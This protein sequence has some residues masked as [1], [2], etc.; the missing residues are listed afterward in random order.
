MR[1]ATLNTWGMRGDWE[2][3]RAAMREGFTVLGADI[4]LLQETI[5]TKDYDQARDVLGDGYELV[6]QRDREPD[7]QGITTASRYPV[8]RTFEVDWPRSPTF[9][10]TC[11]VTELFVPERV[12]VANH[13]PDWQ[14]DHE[15]RRER[16]T[17]AAARALE[18]LDGHVIVGGD[19]D[20]DPDANSVRFWTGRH[21][22]DG[23]SVCYRDAWASRHP[24]EPGH[25]FVPENPY[26]ADWDWP[27]RRID[28][29]LVRCAAHGGPTLR[30]Q[31]CERIFD[32]AASTVS[33]HYGLVADLSG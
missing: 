18:H 14:P 23:M 3:R 28:Y 4:V 6:Q 25:T 2:R 11:L 21:S 12:W 17:A 9:A 5:L 10:S 32:G 7:G 20:A 30:I 24:D 19:L 8:G 26:S 22:L 33:D 1:V 15:Q 27:F 13:F 29:I 31:G 16:Q